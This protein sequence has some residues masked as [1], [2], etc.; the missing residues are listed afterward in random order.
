MPVKMMTMESAFVEIV[1]DL[2]DAEKQLVKSLPKMA[3]AAHSDEL[4]AAFQEHL[5]VTK[6][7]VTRLEQV[8]EMLEER[9]RGKACKGMQGLIE[10]GKEVIEEGA[11]ADEHVA[12]L[13]LIG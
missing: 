10:E 12:D 8:F 11:E 3:K 5:E 2:Y 9:A 4:R 13:E 6:G 7:Q 1:R